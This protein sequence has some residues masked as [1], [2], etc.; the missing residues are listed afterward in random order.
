MGVSAFLNGLI[1][2]QKISFMKIGLSM[3]F[4]VSPCLFSLIY[5]LE[6]GKV[7]CE[8]MDSC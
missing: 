1:N 4:C 5:I 3:S 7:G 2:I 6:V 8:I